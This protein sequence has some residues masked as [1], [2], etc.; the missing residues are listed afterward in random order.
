V[1]TDTTPGALPGGG[2][3][4]PSIFGLLDGNWRA[5]DESM[6]VPCDLT[7]S[8]DSSGQI[9]YAVRHNPAAYYL[10]L[11]SGG[12]GDRSCAADSVALDASSPLDLSA[13]FTFVTPNLVDDMHK[14]DYTLDPAA[15][16]AAGDAW[17]SGFLPQVFA[18]DDY[19]AGRT[20]VFLTWDEGSATD[21]RVPLIVASPY[22]SPG[23]VVRS[24]ATHYDLL[25]TTEDLLG[26]QPYLGH[27]A[28]ATSLRAA[29]GI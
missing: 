17:L 21:A 3:S 29:Y 1:S 12:G 16:I 9:L 5:L 24:P 7:N 18:S 22:V 6:P 26:L 10:E 13:A 4:L 27:A 8:A 19:Q 25:R 15:Q 14:T 23:L 11:R 2:L 28:T 20:I